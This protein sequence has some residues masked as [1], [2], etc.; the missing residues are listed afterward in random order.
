MSAEIDLAFT[1]AG[2]ALH[3]SAAFTWAATAAPLV[4][5]SGEKWGVAILER[6]SDIA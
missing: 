1:A 3:M 2:S 4:T 5:V 6:L